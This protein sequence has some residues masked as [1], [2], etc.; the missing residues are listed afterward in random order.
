MNILLELQLLNFKIPFLTF[1]M[2]TRRL[3]IM[4]VAYIIFQLDSTNW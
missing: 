3:Q 1:I 2:A 4:Y